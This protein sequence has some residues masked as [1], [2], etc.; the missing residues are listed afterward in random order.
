MRGAIGRKLPNSFTPS[1][2]SSS[3]SSR[4]SLLPFSTSSHSAAAEAEEEAAA[5]GV[6]PTAA[7][8]PTAPLPAGPLLARRPR[9]RSARR[10][11]SP[12][13][14]PRGS[15]AAGASRSLRLRSSPRST[16]SCRPSAAAESRRPR[17]RRNR[18]VPGSPSSSGRKMGAGRGKPVPKPGPQSPPVQEENRHI[19]ARPPSPPS[20]RMGREEAERRASGRGDGGGRSGG[21]GGRGRGRGFRGGRG[22]GSFGGRGFFRD[23]EERGQFQ[24]DSDSGHGAGLYLGDNADG[25]KLANRIGAENMNKLVEA[26][27]EMSERVLPSPAHDIYLDA[28]HTNLLIEC[29]P[30]YLMEE[31]ATNPDIDEKP[32]IPLRDALEKMK[33]F[34]M[35]YEGIQSQEEWE[36]VM[37]ELMDRV[38]LMKE[39]VDYYSGPDR[40]TAKKQQEELER[41]AKT[42]PQSA[43]DSVKRFT[44]RAVRSLQSNP[45]WGFDKK[46]QFMDKLVWEASQLYK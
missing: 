5:A 31:F 26:F 18:P 42:L 29:E 28:F 37:K 16:P 7:R 19:R 27:E 11:P 43:P 17:R 6:A 41:V 20:P 3:S 38:P 9:P 33:P 30:E 8:R 45:G 25:E 2:S 34:L 14:L 13:R 1:S 21:R 44:D 46:C 10:R 15:A 39:I 35:L 23:R 22:R 12:S 32:P 4:Y 24:K 36:E 40:V